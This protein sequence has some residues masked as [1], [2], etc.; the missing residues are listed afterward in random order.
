MAKSHV[1]TSPTPSPD[2]DASWK[3]PPPQK[4]I[5]IETFSEYSLQVWYQIEQ[6]PLGQMLV[7][8]LILVFVG[9]GDSET[10]ANSVQLWLRFDIL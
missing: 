7:W 1:L 2:K 4:K 3:E 5:K 6:M 10:K 8:H 9:G